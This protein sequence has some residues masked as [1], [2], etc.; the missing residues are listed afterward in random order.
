MEKRDSQP[1]SDPRHSSFFTLPDDAQPQFALD[2]R[3]SICG[4]TAEFHPVEVPPHGD[5][6]QGER[7][8]LLLRVAA[9]FGNEIL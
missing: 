4:S 7:G 1:L 8:S 5:T 2:G 6:L 9:V 3:W